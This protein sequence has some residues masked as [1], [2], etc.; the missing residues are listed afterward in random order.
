MAAPERRLKALHLPPDQNPYQRLLFDG[1][2]SQDVDCELHMG[3][4]VELFAPSVVRSNDVLHIHWL[5]RYFAG[6]SLLRGTAR[7]L[8]LLLVL[9]YWRLRGRRVLWTVHNLAHHEGE[10]GSFDRALSTAVA[11]LAHRVISHSTAGRVAVA[12]RFWLR[13]PKVV[14]GLHGNY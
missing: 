14:V 11:R 1:L 6:Q 12:R 8:L 7:G 5:H 9:A 4:L 2:Q 10:R 3:Q 13:P